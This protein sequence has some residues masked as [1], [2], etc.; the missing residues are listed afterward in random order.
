MAA[1]Y[2][3]HTRSFHR[4]HN[5]TSRREDVPPPSEVRQCADHRGR[6]EGAGRDPLR[7]DHRTARHGDDQ[8][9]G[10]SGSADYLDDL[11]DNA[12]LNVPIE[13][14]FRVGTMS[15]GWDTVKHELVIECFELTEA[16]AQAGTSADPMTTRSNAKCCA[17]SSMRPLPEFARRGEQVVSA[18]RGDCPFCSLRSNP[19]AICARAPAGSRAPDQ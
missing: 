4:R 17:S 9:P 11:I 10:R 16:D 19:T 6:R 15:L 13:P 8:G 14:E 7:S 5:R 3:H 18:G 12:G 1:L 2:D